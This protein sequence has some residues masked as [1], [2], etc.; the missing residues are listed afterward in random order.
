[1]IYLTRVIGIACTCDYY[2]FLQYS[3]HSRTSNSYKN[4]HNG[5]QS[6]KEYIAMYIHITMSPFTLFMKRVLKIPLAQDS[7]DAYTFLFQSSFY[8][9]INKSIK[10]NTFC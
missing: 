6:S 7:C 8:P 2:S 1:M 9:K 10:T 5:I 3:P 4:N